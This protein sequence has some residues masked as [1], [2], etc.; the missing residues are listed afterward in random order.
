MYHRAKV[1]RHDLLNV[2]VFHVSSHSTKNMLL[3]VSVDF[4]VQRLRRGQNPNCLVIYWRME[5]PRCT[6]IHKYTHVRTYALS[7]EFDG[8]FTTKWSSHPLIYACSGIINYSRLGQHR[9]FLRVFAAVACYIDC[10]QLQA[11]IHTYI[12]IFLD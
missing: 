8:H 4:N 2:F 11:C 1:N 9:H 3:C 10:A 5:D 12:C 6:Y 7:P